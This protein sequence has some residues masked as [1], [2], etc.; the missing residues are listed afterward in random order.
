MLERHIIKY[1]APGWFAV[2]MGTGGLANILYQ[3]RYVFPAG[4][5]LGLV[6]AALADLL[7]FVVLVPWVMR[8]LSFFEYAQRDLHHP[9]AG[10]FFVTM[11]VA[12]IIVGTNVY[13]IWSPYLGGSTTFMIAIIAWMIG[14]AGV[15]FFSFYTTFR[16]IQVEAA[17]KPETT[18]FSWI[19]APIANM[20]TLLLG[21]AVVILSLNF[22]PAWSMSILIVNIIMLGIGF[23]LFVFISAV[24]F[25][26]LVQHAL[27]PA[28][29]TPSFG[30]LLSAVGLAVIA[31]IDVAK[32]A[33]SLGILTS[34][35]LADLGAAIIWGFG[36]WVI[37]ITI[38]ISIHHMRRG[39][40][41]FGLGWWAFIFPLAAYT[42]ASQKIAS[43][44]LSPLTYG[45]SLLLTLLLV[46][47]WVY[48]FIKTVAGAFSGK[49]FMGSPIS[50][51]IGKTI[52]GKS[53]RR[54]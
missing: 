39:G 46:L 37:G 18:N 48:V 24:I 25:V 6:V 49:L 7:Y 2:V 40:I 10:N 4:Q 15:C 19:M 32:S 23:L 53:Q 28:E 38:L 13:T 1:L 35:D 44:F 47:L 16:I 42:I 11:P 43:I 29:L 36:I 54:K 51:P 3:W 31:I 33:Q 9:V 45:F 5:T 27:P 34:V 20:A 12:T 26:R 52:P 8:W 41:P 17:P 14:V 50:Q 22:K 21:N 30:I